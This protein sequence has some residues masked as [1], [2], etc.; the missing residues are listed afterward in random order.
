MCICIYIYIYIYVY[1]Y[2]VVDCMFLQISILYYIVRGAARPWRS[3]SSSRRS[4]RSS[5]LYY[6]I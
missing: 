2:T 5:G 1:V 6:S 4:T 3:W